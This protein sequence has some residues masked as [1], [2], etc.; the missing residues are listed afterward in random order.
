M[1]NMIERETTLRAWGN[2]I[3]LVIPKEDVKKEGLHVDQKVKVVITPVKTLKVKDIFGKL[4]LKINTKELL[5][6]V[7]KELDSKFF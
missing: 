7:D 5:K 2:S 3:G 6:E 1:Y 4:K